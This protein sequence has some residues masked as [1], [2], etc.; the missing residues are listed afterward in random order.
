MRAL[1]NRAQGGMFT[2]DAPQHKAARLGIG[3][4]LKRIRRTM[5]RA[6]AK[7][8][9]PLMALWSGHDVTIWPL[10]TTLGLNNAI[11]IAYGSHLVFELWQD[12]AQE[13]WVAVEFDGEYQTIPACGSE[14]CKLADFDA[15]IKPFIPV[16]FAKE[17]EATS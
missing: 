11:T 6:T 1:Q 8:D 3:S 17:C 16:D 15:A 9:A 5:R 4:F 10:L 2:Y 7:N 12:R 13:H 14:L